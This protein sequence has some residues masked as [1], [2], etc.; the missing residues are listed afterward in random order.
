LSSKAE[1]IEPQAKN[2][3]EFIE[4]CKSGKLDG[5]VAVY[6]TFVSV[7]TTGLIDK[8]LIGVLPESVRFM[9]HNGE[10]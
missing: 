3:A 2:R 10:L 8:E 4:E 5:V 6:R 7:G 1:V 9:A